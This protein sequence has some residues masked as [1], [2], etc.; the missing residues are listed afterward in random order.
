MREGQEV[1]NTSM[2]H[3]KQWP[4]NTPTRGGAAVFHAQFQTKLAPREKSTKNAMSRHWVLNFAEALLIPGEILT[5][6]VP[7]F[8]P[9]EGKKV[10]F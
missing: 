2:C 7:Y 8:T 6:K 1:S 4:D 3:L 10:F 9:F 5:L